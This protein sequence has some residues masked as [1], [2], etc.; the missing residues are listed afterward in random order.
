MFRRGKKKSYMFFSLFH[1]LFFWCEM[2][3]IPAR[4]IP[5]ALKGCATHNRNSRT[6]QGPPSPWPLCTHTGQQPASMAKKPM[7]SLYLMHCDFGEVGTLISYPKSLI[8]FLWSLFH[9][10]KFIR[11]RGLVVYLVL[12]ETLPFISHAMHIKIYDIWYWKAGSNALPQGFPKVLWQ[13]F[14][15]LLFSLSS[16]LFLFTFMCMCCLLPSSQSVSWLVGFALW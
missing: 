1:F 6:Q 14:P 7:L 5:T 4:L 12:K 10:R 3:E 2:T 15:C 9:G 13:I 8:S 16:S 11:V